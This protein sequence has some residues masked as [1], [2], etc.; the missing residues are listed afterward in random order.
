MRDN[1]INTRT[2]T[3]TGEGRENKSHLPR[4][5]PIPGPNTV[6]ERCDSEYYETWDAKRLRNIINARWYA[7]IFSNKTKYSTKPI[8]IFQ[9][10]N[11][12]IL[13]WKNAKIVPRRE[14][15]SKRKF[16]DHVSLS[17]TVI[18]VFRYP[19]SPR[20]RTTKQKKRK[21]GTCEVVIIIIIP[22]RRRKNY[23]DPKIGNRIGVEWQW[24]SI[25][26]IIVVRVSSLKT[27]EPPSPPIIDSRSHIGTNIF[28][29]LS[30]TMGERERENER[31]YRINP[32]EFILRAQ[33]KVVFFRHVTNARISLCAERAKNK[34][35]NLKICRGFCL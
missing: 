1:T 34:N 21:R 7:T 18:L 9:T 24:W 28:T 25:K 33:K 15:P 5:R 13:V 23:Q 11:L 4:S 12:D 10:S 26:S 14:W 16:S 17:S 8:W 30:R 31:W 35:K 29:P 2:T 27:T 6:R 32:T 3:T 22:G 20:Q 19:E